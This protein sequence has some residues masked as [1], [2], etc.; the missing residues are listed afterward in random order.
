[1]RAATGQQAARM[2]LVESRLGQMNPVNQSAAAKVIFQVVVL[3]SNY[4]RCGAND[5]GALPAGFH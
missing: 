5:Q 3:G 2:N 1:F 4:V